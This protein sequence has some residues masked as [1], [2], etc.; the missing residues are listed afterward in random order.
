V[1]RAAGK[2]IKKGNTKK[3]KREKKGMKKGGRCEERPG[4]GGLGR[5]GRTGKAVEANETRARKTEREPSVA[6]KD[7]EDSLYIGDRKG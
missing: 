3:E 2:M 7:Q 1:E 6:K 5:R 4:T